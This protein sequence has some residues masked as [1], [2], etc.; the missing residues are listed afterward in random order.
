MVPALLSV[1]EVAPALPISPE[2]VSVAPAAMSSVPPPAPPTIEAAPGSST[3]VP[4]PS[5]V[6]VPL[7]V[8]VSSRSM[9]VRSSALRMLPSAMVTPEA[10]WCRC[11]C[12]RN[13]AVAVGCER[14]AGDRRTNELD[15]GTGSGCCNV[16]PSFA[17]RLDSQRAPRWCL[18]L[19][20]V[21]VFAPMTMVPQSDGVDNAA[22]SLSMSGERR[23]W[24]R[25]Q[26]VLST[27]FSVAA[28]PSLTIRCCCCR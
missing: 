7:I 21:T 3:K 23:R 8:V 12:H 25:R 20:L 27:L 13:D 28:L 19:R 15:D 14:A 22:C 11:R 5:N 10:C 24:C 4:P 18:Q 2:P 1:S 16:P 6:T 26:I 17:R 9:D